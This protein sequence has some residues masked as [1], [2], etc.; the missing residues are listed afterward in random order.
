MGWLQ[1]SNPILNRGP[2]PINIPSP[3]GEKA[4]A[5][6]K[7]L[8]SSSNPF[9][10]KSGQEITV[11]HSNHNVKGIVV[12]YFVHETDGEHVLVDLGRIMIVRKVA[13]IVS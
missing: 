11:K 8:D 7:K 1:I 4:Q 3:T 13:D 10:P 5:R 9:L 6:Y 12:N 2:L